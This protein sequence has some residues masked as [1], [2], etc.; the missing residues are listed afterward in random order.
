MSEAP[1]ARPRVPVRG[2]VGDAFRLVRAYPRA[3]MLPLLVTQVPVACLTSLASV[4]LFLTVFRDEPY[5]LDK[6]L[7]V[8]ELGAPMFVVLVLL[9]LAA[10][11]GVVGSAAAIVATAGASRGAPPTLVEALDPA[12]TRMG[13]V[14]VLSIILAALVVGLVLTFVG[15]VLVPFV[16]GRL[17]LANT[18]LMLAPERVGG[19]LTRT[20][21]LSRGS[22]LRVWGVVLL[23]LPAVIPLLAVN[24]LAAAADG[25]SRNTRVGVDG[26]LDVAAAL[27]VVPMS[28]FFTAVLTLFYLRLGGPV[29]ER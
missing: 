4:V 5:A 27:A 16:A 15:V 7:P 12:F 18:T 11:A 1:P 10:L 23:S 6:T 29:R 2:T 20:W 14:I 28:A 26:L 19:A 22:V 9:G 8:T 3:T 24:A 17:L 25:A 21:D 13:A